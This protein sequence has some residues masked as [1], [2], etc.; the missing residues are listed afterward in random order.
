MLEQGTGQIMQSEYTGN[1]QCVLCVVCRDVM[2][3][4]QVC[5]CA[6]NV[7]V[8]TKNIHVVKTYKH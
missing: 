4:L 6:V 1:M 3:Q 7:T 8:K 2:Y 5:F